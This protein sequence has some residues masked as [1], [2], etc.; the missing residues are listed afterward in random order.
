MQAKGLNIDSGTGDITT[1]KENVFDF[2]LQPQV[3]IQVYAQDS[4]GSENGG[5]THKTFTTLT[6]TV[7]DVNDVA[8][9]ISL[10]S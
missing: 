1:S 7:E 9:Q 8:P 2:E 3:I 5:S 10:V 6:I 4:M